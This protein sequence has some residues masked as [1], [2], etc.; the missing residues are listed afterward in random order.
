MVAHT[1]RHAVSLAELGP[2]EL[3]LVARAWSERAAAAREGGFA[4]VHA[5]VN[6]GREAGASRS[7]S[8]SQLVWL[9]ERPPAVAAE[10][11][12]AGN[13][14]PACTFLHEEVRDATRLVR[15]TPD[16]VLLSA[17]AGRL[18]YEL[19]IAPLEHPVESAFADA[20]LASAVVLLAEAVRLLHAIEGPVPLNAWVHDGAHWHVELVPRLTVLAGLELGA[21]I[22]VNSLTPEEAA[23]RLRAGNPSF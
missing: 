12:R 10:D 21:G 22:Y 17:Y 2:D 19:L 3:G 16:L 11:E 1:P 13:G 4:Y 5:L 6:E 20:R 7:H 8:H 15:Q 23:E 9:R 18:P 14:C